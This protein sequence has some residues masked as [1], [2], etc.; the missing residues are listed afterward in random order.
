MKSSATFGSKE[1]L[2]GVHCAQSWAM[3]F[4]KVVSLLGKAQGR[5]KRIKKRVE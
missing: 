3:L 1:A 5:G 2:V 4:W